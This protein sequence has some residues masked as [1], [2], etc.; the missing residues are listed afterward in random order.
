VNVDTSEFRAL[1]AQVATLEAEVAELRGGL[2][3]GEA[4]L[5]V[6]EARGYRDGR[7]SVLGTRAAR[8]ATRPRHLRAMDG[9]QP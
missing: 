8:R 5:D 4:L 7:A 1:T 3:L 2:G 9:G 6:V